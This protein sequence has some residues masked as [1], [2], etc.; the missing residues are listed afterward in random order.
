MRSKINRV[1]NSLL[2]GLVLASGSYALKNGNDPILYIIV[3]DG[4]ANA[5]IVPSPNF[6]YNSIDSAIN[7]DA[8]N[9]ILSMPFIFADGNYLYKN[10]GYNVSKNIKVSVP[11]S[12]I[13]ATTLINIPAFEK[14]LTLSNYQ[15]APDY[16]AANPDKWNIPASAVTE[17]KTIDTTIKA[18]QSI[19]NGSII[20][21]D[22]NGNIV[23]STKLTLLDAKNEVDKLGLSTP[24]LI[25][26]GVAGVLLIRK[27]LV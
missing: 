13:G 20:T 8:Y 25:G 26:L 21:K 5:S 14:I 24:I 9:A 19:E 15:I 12:L 17:Q 2:N 22:Q 6:T 7:V 4:I 23:E 10:V 1:S 27:L 3:K 11:L 18:N 16:I